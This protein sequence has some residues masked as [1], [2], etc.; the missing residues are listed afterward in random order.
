MEPARVN[1][2][3]REH[4][5]PQ[6]LVARLAGLHQT[7]FS[8]WLRNQAEISPRVPEEIELAIVALVEFEDEQPYGVNLKRIM[9][10]EPVIRQKMTAMRDARGAQLRRASEEGCAATV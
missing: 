4:G 9:D 8:L 5:Y 3:M 7:T 2:T 1:L 6:T 10:F